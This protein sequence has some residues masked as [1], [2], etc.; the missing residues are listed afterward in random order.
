MHIVNGII[1]ILILLTI[2][3]FHHQVQLAINGRLKFAESPQMKLDKDP[4]LTNINMVKLKGKK[5]MIRPSQV[6]LTKG[7]EVFIGEK[8]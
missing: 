3:I 6:K 2:V 7:K 8:R 5:A 4:F 1:L